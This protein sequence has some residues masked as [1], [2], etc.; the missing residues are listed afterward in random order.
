MVDRFTQPIRRDSEGFL[1]EAIHVGSSSGDEVSGE[2]GLEKPN[3][4]DRRRRPRILFLSQCLPF[5]PH[6]GVTR[7]TY[8]ILKELHRMFDVSL[9]PFSRR[10][11]Q[12]DDEDRVF[13]TLALRREFKDVMDPVRI[14]ADYSLVERLRNHALSVVTRK[15]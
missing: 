4:R 14:N 7:R 2:S 11:H 5:P 9:V 1:K 13:S 15:P 6:S 12:N 8:H 3:E 10:V